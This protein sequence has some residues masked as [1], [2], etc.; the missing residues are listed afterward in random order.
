[1]AKGTE[2]PCPKDMKTARQVADC[3]SKSSPPEHALK[4]DGR[5]KQ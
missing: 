1:M 3:K 2:K 4:A 5:K